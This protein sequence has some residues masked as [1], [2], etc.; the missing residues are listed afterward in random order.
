MAEGWLE[1]FGTAPAH[2]MEGKADNPNDQRVRVS[3]WWLLSNMLRLQDDEEG[4]TGIL[5][6]VKSLRSLKEA[7]AFAKAPGW[8]DQFCSD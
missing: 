6:K 5:P 7:I 2:A 8:V 4:G 3:L 1:E